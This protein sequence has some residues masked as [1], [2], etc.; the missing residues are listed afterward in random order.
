V[1]VRHL[2]KDCGG[3]GGGG[4]GWNPFS[5]RAPPFI[6]PSPNARSCRMYTPLGKIGKELIVADRDKTATWYR[7]PIGSSSIEAR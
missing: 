3:I 2:Q 4:F 7:K 5:V 1:W 6:L